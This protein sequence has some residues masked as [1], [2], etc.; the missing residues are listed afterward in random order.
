MQFHLET[1]GFAWKLLNQVHFKEIRFTLDNVMKIRVSQGIGNSVCKAQLLTGF[2][3]E[4]LW[5][6][7]LLGVH[8][9]DTL[10]NTVIFV[11]GK[12]FAL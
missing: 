2:E 7:G 12:G 1:I 6:I 5:S 11:M 10:L 3:E 9:P 8:N 4:Y